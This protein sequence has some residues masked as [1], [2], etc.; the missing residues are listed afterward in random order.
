MAK[1]E[2]LTD[3]EEMVMKT[4][5]DAE[6]ELGL[7]DITLGLNETCKKNWKPHTVSTFLARL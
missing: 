1:C 6:R 5:W 2:H 4:V 3:C 7:M